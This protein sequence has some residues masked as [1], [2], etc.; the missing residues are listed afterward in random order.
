M[1]RS[2]LTV[3]GLDPSGGAGIAADLKV[4]NALGVHGMVVAS[5]LTAQNTQ[6]VEGVYAVNGGVFERQLAVLLDDIIPAALKTG[7]L[8]NAELVEILIS[9]IK[10]YKL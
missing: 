7:V 9:T 4:F 3:A 1:I 2:A 6:R 5:S 10:K 8:C